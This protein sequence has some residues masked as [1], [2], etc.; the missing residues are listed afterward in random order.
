MTCHCQFHCAEGGYA[1]GIKETGIQQ[2]QQTKL[3]D[4][5]E[6][7]NGSSRKQSSSADQLN[8]QELQLQSPFAADDIQQPPP[9]LSVKNISHSRKRARQTSPVEDSLTHSKL[10]QLAL[11]YRQTGILPVSQSDPIM[12][13]RPTP[14]R[15]TAGAAYSFGLPAVPSPPK[16]SMHAFSAAAAAIPI[17][18]SCAFVPDSLATAAALANS[19]AIRNSPSA[20]L[21]RQQQPSA[22][23]EVSTDSRPLQSKLRTL[24]QAL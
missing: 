20:E 5:P 21:D 11:Q 18:A 10:Q 8:K 3:P 1:T 9:Q 12:I 17:H 16:H 6:L 4:Q 24:H 23:Q 13:H 7:L 15:P 22:K 2:P 14:Q 19:V